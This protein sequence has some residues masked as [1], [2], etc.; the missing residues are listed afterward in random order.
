MVPHKGTAMVPDPFPMFFSPSVCHERK[1]SDNVGIVDPNC[2]N[3]GSA[4]LHHSNI[5]T[6]W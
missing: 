1:L 4:D 3:M 5:W 6:V 2:R